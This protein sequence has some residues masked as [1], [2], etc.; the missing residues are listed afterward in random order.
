MKRSTFGGRGVCLLAIVVLSTVASARGADTTLRW[1]FGKGQKLG[2][3]LTQKTEMT[4]DVAGQK[5]ETTMTQ[6]TDMTWEVKGVD[7]DGNGDM[8]Q[9]IDRVRFELTAPGGGNL[10]VDTADAE[11]AQGTPEAMSKL[12]RAMAGSPFTMTITQRGEL[13]DVKVPAKIVDAFKDAGPAG[14]MLGNEETLKNMFGNSLV[15][16][17]EAA[18]APGKSW[19]GARKMPMPPLGTMVMNMTYTL[20]AAAGPIENIG[21]DVKLEIEQ[22]EGSPI[23]MKLTSQDMKGHYQFDN[24]TGILKSTAVV[25][26]MKMTVTANGQQFAQ[27]IE[28]TVK[29]ELKK[30]GGSK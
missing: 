13:R 4:M 26:K 10:H 19:K 27:D 16:F 20:E 9:T 7:K 12:F 2:Y 14:A 21:I 29:M 17:P 18:V 22:K 24:S 28:S 5:M 30:D 15:P 3:V 8:A 23:E 11:D 6:T 25:Q 1:K